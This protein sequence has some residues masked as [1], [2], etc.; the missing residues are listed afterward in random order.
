[1]AVYVFALQTLSYTSQCN[2]FLVK[3]FTATVT[4][5]TRRADS[6]QLRRKDPCQHASV[7]KRPKAGVRVTVPTTSQF[8][9]KEIIL[10]LVG[11]KS[12]Q[13]LYC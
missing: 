12:D 5:R 10:H 4:Q 1:M 2:A 11:T 3:G 13:R 7:C 9:Q 6:I 8:R